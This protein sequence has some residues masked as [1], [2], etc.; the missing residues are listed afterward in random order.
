MKIKWLFN[1]IATTDDSK[2]TLYQNLHYKY[3][4][5][6]FRCV[7]HDSTP[8]FVSPSVRWLVHPLVHLS[9][10]FTFFVFFLL[11]GLQPHCSCPNDQVTSNTAPAHLHATGVAVYPALFFILP[12]CHLLS[13]F[14]HEKTFCMT[15]VNIVVK[16][17]ALWKRRGKLCLIK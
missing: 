15:W 6:I 11:F 5:Y 14:I 12:F 9:V 3:I 13:F 17:S 10:H 4:L 2:K 7:L 16:Y 8:H 1:L